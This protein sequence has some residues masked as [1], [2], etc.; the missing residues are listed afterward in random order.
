MMNY[1]SIYYE[2]R[3]ASSFMEPHSARQPVAS[4]VR[5]PVA[6]AAREWT[7]SQDAYTLH[8]QTRRK[9][10]RRKVITV[11]V[12]H[13][14]QTD[15]ADM[16]SI[17]RY[18]DD[19]KFLLCCI[20]TFSRYAF[21]KAIPNKGSITVRNAFD[22]I[23]TESGRQP[24]HLQSDKGKEYTNALMA[25]H[26]RRLGI[27]FYTSEN[28]DIKCAIVERFQRTLKQKI[29]RMFTRNKSYRYVD[30]LDDLVHSYNSTW[31]ST[32]KMAPAEVNAQNEKELYPPRYKAAGKKKYKFKVGDVVRLAR[33]KEIFEKGYYI[34]WT[35]ELFTID[36]L[37]HTTPVTYSVK[38]YAG[39]RIKGKFYTQEL[40]KVLGKKPGEF[41]VEKVLKT[42]TVRGKKQYLVRWAG[43]S[44]KHDSWVDDILI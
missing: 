34:R 43:Y 9:F 36:S 37:H 27:N 10:P 26:L 32:I 41:E 11:G 39:E 42:R 30:V 1:E 24:T 31:H 21:V 20:D 35:K 17:S 33:K 13:L 2:P 3:K 19:K 25:S 5:R 22:Q 44:S 7:M 14:W 23:L 8:R 40:Q 6:S 12:D 15:L 18:N 28:D 29:W 4:A 38:D 16:S